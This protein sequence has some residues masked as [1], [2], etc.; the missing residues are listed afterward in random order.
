M[1]LYISRCGS[2]AEPVSRAREMGEPSRTE[3][4]RADSARFQPQRHIV[5]VTCESPT[6]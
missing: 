3:P 6:L 4:S 5:S 1:Q 2:R